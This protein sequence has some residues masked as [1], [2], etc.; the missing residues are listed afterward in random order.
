MAAIRWPRLLDQ[1]R[2][3]PGRQR[4]DRSRARRPVPRGE[5]LDHRVGE[6]AG[7]RLVRRALGEQGAQRAAPADVG[8]PAERPAR[9]GGA[10]S[11]DLA[12]RVDPELLHAGRPHLPRLDRHAGPGEPVPRGRRAGRRH[13]GGPGL[14]GAVV[15]PA[16]RRRLGVV[17]LAPQE[18]HPAAGR[19]PGSRASPAARASAPRPP[20]RS[21]R[22]RRPTA[23][24]WRP[25]RRRCASPRRPRRAPSASSPAVPGT[26]RRG[27]RA[28]R[29][30]AAGR[31]GQR[32]EASRGPGAP[33][34]R[35]AR[36]STPRCPGPRGRAAAPPR[37]ARRRARPG[38]SAG[39][40][41]PA[42]AARPGG[43]RI[44][45]PAC[46]TP[47]RARWSRPAP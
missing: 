11:G 2:P 10:G 32:V 43:P 5:H 47:C 1:H 13:V 29:W 39:S 21:A 24:R 3:G 9:L 30:T 45:G 44:P 42:T 8:Q 15:A 17:E 22:R 33:A 28:R 20:A 12:G 46:R 41:R 25:S 35:R 36:R 38:R 7:D 34:G 14:A 4:H 6:L 27:S 26:G 23:G 31:R 37:R 40:R 19:S 16:A 18:L